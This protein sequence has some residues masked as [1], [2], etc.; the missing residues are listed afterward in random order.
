[1]TKKTI[2][3]CLIVKDEEKN[4]SRCLESIKNVVDEIVIVDTGSKDSTIAIGKKYTNKVFSHKFKNDFSEARNYALSKCTKEWII[5][6]DADEILE[7]STELKSQLNEKNDCF[8]VKIISE[9]E[10]QKSSVHKRIVLFRNSKKYFWSGIVHEKIVESQKN[11]PKSRMLKKVCIRHFGYNNLEQT[12][13]KR[14]RNYPLIIKD[15]KQN[16]AR[17]ENKFYLARNYFLKAKYI[18]SKNNTITRESENCLKKILQI[19]KEYSSTTKAIDKMMKDLFDLSNT[20]ISFKNKKESLELI[21]IKPTYD[22]KIN[23]ADLTVKV[24]S[25]SKLFLKRIENDY[26]HFETKKPESI[27][28]FLSIQNKVDSSLET[29]Y[30]DKT[31][32][33]QIEKNKEQ[34]YAWIKMPN[35]KYACGKALKMTFAS[36]LYDK[37]TIF[38]HASSIVR[39]NKGYV[40]CGEKGAGKSTIASLSDKSAVLN[41][42]TTI[43]QKK[44]KQFFLYGNPLGGEYFKF[45]ETL[46][47]NSKTVKLHRIFFIKQSDSHTLS[48]ISRA[49]VIMELTKEEMFFKFITRKKDEYEK[50]FELIKNISKEV[51]CNYLYFKKD[52]HFW[53]EIDE[54]EKYS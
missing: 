39:N 50:V 33:L 28:L 43:I 25:E 21:G 34:A 6:I 29:I 22:L 31:L 11:I 14:K 36:I 26:K 3:A 5:S 23:I 15:M 7:H 9:K 44:N 17:E 18:A 4:L 16:P 40:F 53:R 46:K 54:L 48:E 38:L 37:Q 30:E 45:K 47:P 35:S 51:K 2:S 13:K 49:N 27:K 8:K 1:M 12:E 19:Y 10:N 42:E 41:D 52:K 24:M 20:I 32:L